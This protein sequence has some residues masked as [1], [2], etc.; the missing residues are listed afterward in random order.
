MGLAQQV[1]SA[2]GP[3]KESRGSLRR[4]KRNGSAISTSRLEDT[5]E[6]HVSKRLLSRRANTRNQ[7][8][9]LPKL[10]I[11]IDENEEE[12]PNGNKKQDAGIWVIRSRER[13]PEITFFISSDL[14]TPDSL[15]H[16]TSR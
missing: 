3:L 9:C 16:L 5:D 14:V 2:L 1:Q 10:R 7:Q 11:A 12:T 6:Q 8:S 15:S 13:K 4:S